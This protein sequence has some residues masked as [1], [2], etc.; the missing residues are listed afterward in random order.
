MIFRV[1]VSRCQTVRGTGLINAGVYV[2]DAE[3]LED[4]AP[5]A[6]CS[7]E[8]EVI[9]AALRAGRTVSALE[10]EAPFVDIGLPEDYARVKSR[11]PRGEGVS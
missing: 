3:L 7:L 4:V 6:A 1:C 11:L 8:R 9:P 10:V 2:M 5:G